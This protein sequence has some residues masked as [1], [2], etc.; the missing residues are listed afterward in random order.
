MEAAGLGRH[1]RSP[2]GEFAGAS[3]S[4]EL[5]RGMKAWLSNDTER[6]IEAGAGIEPANSGFADRDLT[7]WLSRRL[8][9]T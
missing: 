9:E 4:T 7:T 6:N 2:E 5:A 1:R 8:S 3:E